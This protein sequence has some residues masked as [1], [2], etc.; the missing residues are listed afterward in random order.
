M[1]KVSRNAVPA[2]TVWA[3]AAVTAVPPGRHTVPAAPITVPSVLRGKKTQF[4]LVCNESCVSL[5]VKTP[6]IMYKTGCHL[7]SLSP[8]ILL[9]LSF[10]SFVLRNSSLNSEL[11]P[12]IA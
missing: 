3:P 11:P 7:T 12:F 2:A 6:Y 8:I 10:P 5:T 1:V 9:K 4:R